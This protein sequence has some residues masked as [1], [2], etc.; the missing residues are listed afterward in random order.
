MTWNI[1]ISGH[2]DLS[3]DAKKEAENALV[4][5][6]REF[7]GYLREREGINVTTATIYTNTTDT[8]NLLEDLV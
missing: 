3:D 4:E 5:A 8:V 7:T 6:T 2:D 1:A